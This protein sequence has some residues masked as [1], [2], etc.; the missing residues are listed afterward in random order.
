MVCNSD[1][2]QMCCTLSVHFYTLRV[3]QGVCVASCISNGGPCNEESKNHCP[4]CPPSPHPPHRGHITHGNRHWSVYKQDSGTEISEWGCEP[5][6]EDL[7]SCLFHL[8]T[9][10]TPLFLPFKPPRK[11]TF[12]YYCGISF[13]GG[14]RMG[15]RKEKKKK[16]QPLI[17]FVFDFY[18]AGNCHDVAYTDH[19]VWDV[20][21]SWLH[22]AYG[23]HGPHQDG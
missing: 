18:A 8:S 13:G 4:N 16:Q 3:K 19:T 11:N 6:R 14:E 7:E 23:G 22:Y 17:T 2:V 15:K 5:T 9:P 12:G 1:S 21:A 20:I 10:S